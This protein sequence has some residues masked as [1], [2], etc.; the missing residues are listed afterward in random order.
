[1]KIISAMTD[2]VTMI[3]LYNILWLFMDEEKKVK[4]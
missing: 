3:S 2:R 4:I 1:M